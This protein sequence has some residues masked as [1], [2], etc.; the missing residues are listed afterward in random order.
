[1][2]TTNGNVDVSYTGLPLIIRF[3]GDVIDG[4]PLTI[5]VSPRGFTV[6]VIEK[7]VNERAPG[8]EAAVVVLAV[9]VVAL[10]S[11]TFVSADAKR[12]NK[13]TKEDDAEKIKKKK[14]I[15]DDDD[16]CFRS[17]RPR[18]RRRRRLSRE[19]S[20][21]ISIALVLLSSLCNIVLREEV[22]RIFCA[23]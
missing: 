12:E 3:L 5:L 8:K 23:T 10:R 11:P 6:G 21:L 2:A 13:Q 18:C 22:S 20:M 19:D 9:V 17:I 16:D 4:T 7:F 1:M 14:N 15:K